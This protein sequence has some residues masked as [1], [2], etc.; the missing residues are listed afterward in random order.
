MTLSATE[1][2]RVAK[3]AT[4]TKVKKAVIMAGLPVG[5]ALSMN[6]L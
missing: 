3:N 5:G 2:A 4:V 6:A 1:A